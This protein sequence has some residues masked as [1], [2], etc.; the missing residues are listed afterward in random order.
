MTIAIFA[1]LAS[2]TL[3]SGIDD[4]DTQL[5]VQSGDGA[6]FPSP[7]ASQ[8]AIIAI[9]SVDG[10]VEFVK[11]TGRTG[12]TLT[13]VR[14]QESSTAIAFA[15]GSAVECRPTSGV[16]TNMLQKTGG[17]TLSGTTTLSGTID[18]GS[19]GSILGGEF[20]GKVRGDAGVTTNEF[21]VPSGGGAP[22][23]GGS[24]VLTAANLITSLPAGAGLNRPGMVQFWYGAVDAIPDGYVLC[25][26][27]N[28][29]PD[30]RD[31]FILGGGGVQPSSGGS[32]TTSSGGDV[33][34]SVT[35]GHSITQAE[36]PNFSPRLYVWESGSNGPGQMENFGNSGLGPAQ[37]VAGN[38]DSNTYAYRQ[39]TVAGNNLIEALGSGTAHTHTTPAVAGHT[40]VFAPPYRS[41]FAIMKT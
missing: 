35:G 32:L 23:I 28:S 24:V 11:C 15:S 4:N 36:L 1:N 25:D 38:A 30:L 18:A 10:D 8:H 26:G 6:L 29:T 37:G 3:A 14:G 22:T 41:L 5:T 17:D 20:T 7:G 2:S 13:I 9:E 33:S 16:M 39:A 40:H 31:K 12:D 19:S 21:D 27:T 34:A